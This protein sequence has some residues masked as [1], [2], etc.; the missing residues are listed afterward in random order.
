MFD[1][2]EQPTEAQEVANAAYVWRKK[3]QGDLIE[4]M[5]NVDIS[6]ESAEYWFERFRRA[7]LRERDTKA[8]AKKEHES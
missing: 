5:R 2:H 3:V 6:L 4:A 7:A 1:K 8:A